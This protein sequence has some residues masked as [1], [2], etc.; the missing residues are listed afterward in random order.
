MRYGAELFLD[1]V[2]KGEILRPAA[3][4]T[5][6]AALVEDRMTT[7]EGFLRKGVSLKRVFF[8]QHGFFQE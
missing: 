3:L 4:L 6:Q 5:H 2:E 1:K 7:L 8:P